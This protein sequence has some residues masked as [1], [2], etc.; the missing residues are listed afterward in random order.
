M[1]TDEVELR[2]SS[3]MAD[4]SRLAFLAQAVDDRIAADRHRAAVTVIV[5]TV[6][7][8]ATLFLAAVLEAGYAPW[9]M[10]ALTIHAIVALIAAWHIVSSAASLQEVVADSESGDSSPMSAGRNAF[11][12]EVRRARRSAQ[13]V[14]Y[15]A[16]TT[17]ATAS[18]LTGNLVWT[19]ALHT[20]ADEL[21]T[22]NEIGDEAGGGTADSSGGGDQVA[23]QDTVADGTSE[24]VV[25][26]STVAYAG[27]YAT[28]P[29][30]DVAAGLSAP[31]A[32]LATDTAG[33]ITGGVVTAAGK[34]VSELRTWWLDRAGGVV[35]AAT[36]ETIK[37]AINLIW[38]RET[39]R[40]RPRPSNRRTARRLCFATPSRLRCA[41][42]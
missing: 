39:A 9:T 12:D 15:L 38:K 21:N 18:I 11:T 25:A 29:L 42:S 17:V 24:E 40:C 23:G 32:Q 2:G 13:R 27:A 31:V 8:V 4:D 37:G 5:T 36:G 7:V 14:S 20:R 35:D 22:G 33:E 26:V 3:H 41:P 19:T 34:S 16:W 28:A 6:V 30:R 10:V 1:L